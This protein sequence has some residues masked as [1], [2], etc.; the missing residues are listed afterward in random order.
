MCRETSLLNNA[1]EWAQSTNYCW[2][3]TNRSKNKQKTPEEQNQV[4]SRRLG[5]KLNSK[6]QAQP[7]HVVVA[8][9]GF[10]SLHTDEVTLQ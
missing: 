6:R 3:G 7:R 10:H 4:K 8:Y 9:L 5:Y 2:K 1:P